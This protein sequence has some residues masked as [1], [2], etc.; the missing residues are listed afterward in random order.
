MRNVAVVVVFSLAGVTG[1]AALDEEVEE[2]VVV[3]AAVVVV[4]GIM[5]DDTDAVVDAV[6]FGLVAFM[7]AVEGCAVTR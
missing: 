6:L 3:L 5:E 7:F 2:A 1:A 4:L